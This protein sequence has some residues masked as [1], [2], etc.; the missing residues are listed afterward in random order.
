MPRKAFLPQVAFGHGFCH[1]DRNETR[2]KLVPEKW[3]YFCDNLTV[4]LWGE[5]GAGVS[6]ILGW[7]LTERSFRV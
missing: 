3:G 5:M 6:G 2:Q 1:S 4:L 7:K